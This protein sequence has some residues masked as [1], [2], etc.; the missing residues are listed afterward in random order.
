[1]DVIIAQ[2]VTSKRETDAEPMTKPKP[3]PNR[4]GK[5]EKD[6]PASSLEDWISQKVMKCSRIGS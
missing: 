5:S 2:P 4:L 1:M 3:V 6:R